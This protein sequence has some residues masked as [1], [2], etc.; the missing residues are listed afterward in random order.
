MHLSRASRS[1][2]G[3]RFSLGLAPPSEPSHSTHRYNHV[4]H[5]P[6]PVT[7]HVKALVRPSVLSLLLSL[8][9]ELASL[10]HSLG[11]HVGAPHSQLFNYYYF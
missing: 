3:L 1:N 9:P 2:L 10:S 6:S 11:S 5:N 8:E 7:A 4:E